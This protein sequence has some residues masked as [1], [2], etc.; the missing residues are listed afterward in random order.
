MSFPLVLAIISAGGMIYGIY[1]G[2]SQNAWLRSARMADGK[3]IELIEK[4]GGEGGRTYAPKVRFTTLS[5]QSVEF[6]ASMSSS[7]PSF[8]V[9]ERVRVAYLLDRTEYSI[10]T[11]GQCY[12]V[13]VF[14]TVL[15]AAAFL[16]ALIFLYGDEIMNYLHPAQI[17]PNK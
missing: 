7:P 10:F 17:V 14:V 8:R 12:G 9:G 1:Q 3:V 4:S 16:I 11:L 2:L 13:S 6:V 15:S 5:G